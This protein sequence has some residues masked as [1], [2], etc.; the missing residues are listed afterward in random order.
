MKVG[1]ILLQNVFLFASVVVLICILL[2]LVPDSSKY[3]VSFIERFWLN[4]AIVLKL[5]FGYSLVTS[6]GIY[7]T[8]A[9]AGGRSF[10]LIILSLLLVT[11]FGVFIAF[12]NTQYPHSRTMTIVDNVVSKISSIP[13]LIWAT[14]LLLASFLLFEL[15]PVYNDISGLNLVSFLALLLPVL[16]ISLGDNILGDTINRV[17]DKVIEIRS[18]LYYQSMLSRG[19]KTKRHIFR[20][21]VP[22]LLTVTSSRIYYL[23]TGMIIV[24]FIYN[25]QGLGWMIWQSVIREGEKDYALV[26][27]CSILIILFVIFLNILR[28]VSFRLVNPQWYR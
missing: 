10:L 12:M 14:I 1:K 9:W 17:Q 18:T 16:S 25:W 22:E 6:Y 20:S 24:E 21:I 19:L 4:I 8:V 15:V 27:A 13:I 3:G 11:G 7:E 28:D 2:S 26:L 5:D 23:I